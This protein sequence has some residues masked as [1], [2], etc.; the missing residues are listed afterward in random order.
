MSPAWA[1]S[2]SIASTARATTPRWAPTRPACTAAATP[3]RASAISTGTQSAVTTTNASRAVAVTNPSVSSNAASRGLSTT[4]MRSPWTWFIHT[5]R[6][7]G[8]P[9]PLAR[10]ARLAATAS[11][12]SPTW[13]PRLKVSNGG[14]ETPPARVVVTRRIR[15]LTRPVSGARCPPGGADVRPRPVCR[16]LA[17]KLRPSAAHE[18]WHVDIVV[19]TADAQR[20]TIGVHRHADGFDRFEQG[21][22]QL[23]GLRRLDPVRTAGLADQRLAPRPGIEAGR[24]HGD[25]HL[26]AQ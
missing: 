25:P 20:R 12:S 16:A 10:R 18:G 8:R 14:A 19:V 13:S 11:G 4:S 26:V 2:F 15:T 6:L 23:A 22:R 17:S 24:D 1:P 9:M 5:S 3:A 7:A 21:R